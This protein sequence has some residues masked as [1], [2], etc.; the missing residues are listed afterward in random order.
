MN[1]QEFLKNKYLSRVAFWGKF[2]GITMIVLYVISVLLGLRTIVGAIPGIVGI[3]TGYFLYQTGKQ[4]GFMKDGLGETSELQLYDNLGKFLLISGILFII[5]FILVL[6]L[7][8]LALA[9]LFTL[10]PD[11]Y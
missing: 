9:G 6:I 1:E 2:L 5:G 11:Y 8:I 4:A 7:F 10:F 3:F